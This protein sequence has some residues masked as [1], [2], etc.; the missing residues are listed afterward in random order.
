MAD[1]SYLVFNHSTQGPPTDG[2]TVFVVSRCSTGCDNITLSDAVALNLTNIPTFILDVNATAYA[3][4]ETWEFAF[5]VCKPN[6]VV[7]T[8][9]VI[10]N[11][12]GFLEVLPVPNGKRY[13][14]QGILHPTQ[15]PAMLSFALSALST[16]AGPMNTTIFS[17][18]GSSIVQADFL[19][20]Q[21]QI[22]S[23]PSATYSGPSIVLTILPTE[24]LAP[25]FG[26]MLQSASK[27]AQTD[28]DVRAYTDIVRSLPEWLFWNCA[29]SGEAVQPPNRI[30]VIHAFYHRFYDHVRNAIYSDGDYAFQA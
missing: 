4:A 8:R 28:L 27:C 18:G 24:I 6:A 1:P 21:Q 16:Y 15:T 29:R 9:E 13:I 20:G 14:S 23:L 2:S 17:A 22:D 30:R 12:T 25:K 3:T 5:L 19:F 11:G 7:Q 10:S 26:A